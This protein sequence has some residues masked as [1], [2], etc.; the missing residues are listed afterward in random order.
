MTDLETIALRK[1]LIGGQSYEDDFTVLWGELPIG[2][3]MK[4]SG[5]PSRA[6]QRW[7]GFTFYGPPSLGSCSGTGTDPDDCKAKFKVAWTR[8]R[9]DLT[10]AD[11]AKAYEMR[12]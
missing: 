10:D 5:V 8:I 9:A 11:I 1:T 4:R 12:R 3:I 2:R 7:Y 6:D